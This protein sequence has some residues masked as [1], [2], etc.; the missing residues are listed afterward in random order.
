M[1][2]VQ[3]V[4]RNIPAPVKRRI[5]D[6]MLGGGHPSVPALKGLGRAADIYVW[7]A[8][9]TVDTLVPVHNYF[10][11][12]FPD[13]ETATD[14][15][16]EL[17]ASD[18]RRIGSAEIA[19]PHLGTP[20]V[21]ISKLLKD[22][23]IAGET[24]GG[25]IWDLRPPPA[26]KARLEAMAEPFLLWD[27]SYIGYV[28]PSGQVSFV[29]GID[30]SRVITEKEIEIGWPIGPRD[31][32]V[33]TPEIPLLAGETDWVDVILQNRSRLPRRIELQA[34]DAAGS[35]REWAAEL[36]RYGTNRF[37]IDPSQVAGLKLDTPLSLCVSGLPTRY[38]RAVIFK[39]FA[40][41]AISAMHC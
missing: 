22:L 15:R 13:L 39:H 23:N 12:L 18:G 21:R 1:S 28:G 31:S 10:S 40:S 9:D 17:Y 4:K 34:R 38:G 36:P 41:G 6:W 14:A 20:A 16:I 2:F 5:R 3:L 37:R 33:A 26:V 32:F 29:H 7:I 27:R 11:V 19:V 25:V 35:T 30:K 8:D 24:Y